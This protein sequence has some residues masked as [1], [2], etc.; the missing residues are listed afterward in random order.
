MMSQ[1]SKRTHLCT[2]VADI[3]SLVEKFH[4]YW[5]K[6]H[7]AEPENFPLEM[8]DVEWMEHF[9]IFVQGLDE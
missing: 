4:A 8:D 5:Q 3:V 7:A 6:N 1:P 2:A 9:L